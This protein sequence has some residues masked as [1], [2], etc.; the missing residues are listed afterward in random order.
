MNSYSLES[1]VDCSSINENLRFAN[2]LGFRRFKHQ[3][4]GIKVNFANVEGPLYTIAVVVPVYYI[5]FIFYL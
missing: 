3:D 4:N 2:L 1:D 5:Y